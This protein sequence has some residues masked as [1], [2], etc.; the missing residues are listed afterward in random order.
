MLMMKKVILLIALVFPLLVKAQYKAEIIT[1]PS[2]NV[3]VFLGSL[4]QSNG[5]THYK[6]KVDILGGSWI[7]SSTGETTFYIANREALSI[8]ETLLGGGND[9]NFSLHA[10][11]NPYG[12]IDFYL[13]T[14][15]YTAIAVKSCMLQGDATQLIN[16]TPSPNPPAGLT[17]I[18][19][20]NIIYD[21]VTD[22]RG[23]VGIGTTLP[24][25][26]FHIAQD[27]TMTGD[28]DA[29]QMGITGS[30]PAKRMILGYDVNG[31]GFGFIKAGYY[32]RQWTNLAL[33]PNGG[34]VGIGTTTP[35]AMLAV[36]G[37]IHAQQER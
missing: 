15:A 19:A 10:Y 16:N 5:G 35:D 7:S 18:T 36:K 31:A 6:L 29:A 3:Y 1:T 22:P 21:L 8:H 25:F 13:L 11:N 32:Q 34:N 14:S 37:T 2:S 28:V 4:G 24:L 17:E 27:V 23:K 26:N 30:D 20:L 12:G 9:G 33:Q